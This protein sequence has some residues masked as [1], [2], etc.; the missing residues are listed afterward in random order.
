[1]KYLSIF[2]NLLVIINSSVNFFIYLNKDPKFLLCFYHC[3]SSSV[4]GSCA[5][6][7]RP[8]S[9]TDPCVLRW[10]HKHFN[11][12]Y[13]S[14]SILYSRRNC[15]R[16]YPYNQSARS[17][18]ISITNITHNSTSTTNNTSTPIAGNS[19]HVFLVG[20]DDS[21]VVNHNSKSVGDTAEELSVLHKPEGNDI[22]TEPEEAKRTRKTVKVTNL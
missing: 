6:I 4:E 15:S 8:I 22:L 2:S 20:V 16:H 13:S 14:V 11:L 12:K 1:M 18:F 19:P 17:K 5:E 10:V 9:N 3:I 21:S 7:C